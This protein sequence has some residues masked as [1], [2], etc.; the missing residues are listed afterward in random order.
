MLWF[1]YHI[2]PDTLLHK[3]DVVL[4]GR[5]VCVAVAAPRALVRLSNLLGFD[6][7]QKAIDQ[8]GP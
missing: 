5:A 1:I 2:Y 7:Y 8:T 6:G 4:T 3:G